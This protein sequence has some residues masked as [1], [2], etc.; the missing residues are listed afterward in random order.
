MKLQVTR[1][2]LDFSGQAADLERLRQE[3]DRHHYIRLPQLF[4]PELLE[5]IQYGLERAEFYPRSDGAVDS[6]ELT[7]RANTTLGLLLM[8]MNDDRLLELFQQMTG[9]P[10]LSCFHGRVFHM[11]RGHYDTWHN[12]L[13]NTRT[14]AVSMNLS[15]RPYQGGIVE[16]RDARSRQILSQFQNTG[17]GDGV[18]FRIAPHLEHHLTPLEGELPRITFGGWYHQQPNRKTYLKKRLSKTRLTRRQKELP[19]DLG[20]AAQSPEAR[21]SFRPVQLCDHVEIDPEVI[22]RNIEE[23][24]F[25]IN[26][27]S[28]SYYTLNRVGARIWEFLTEEKQLQKVFEATKECYDVEPKVLRQDITQLVQH[29]QAIGFL[30]I[31]S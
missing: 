12:D 4:E 7:M 31:I 17:Y 26:V 23:E 10:P 9:T 25:L 22:F 8:V 3:F 14:V 29:L 15:P 6:S 27:K 1:R 18:V 11:Y 13:L 28:D 16:I 5:R 21:E 30:R 24:L 2:G 20:Q 19:V